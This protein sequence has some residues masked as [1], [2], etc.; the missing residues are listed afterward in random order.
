MNPLLVNHTGPPGTYLPIHSL[1]ARQGALVKAE[2]AAAAAIEQRL[3]GREAEQEQL[4][5]VGT[6]ADQQKSGQLV[7]VSAAAGWGKSALLA[8]V[9]DTLRAKVDSGAS[10]SRGE[11]TMCVLVAQRWGFTMLISGPRHDSPIRPYGVLVVFS[12]FP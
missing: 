4:V 3:V 11:K 5:V 1:D 8:G 6:K 9:I 7:L 12:G 10:A 2:S